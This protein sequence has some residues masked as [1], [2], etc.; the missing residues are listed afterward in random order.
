MQNC[1]FTDYIEKQQQELQKV[2]RGIKDGFRE[3]TDAL[4]KVDQEIQNAN[5]TL[6]TA[7]EV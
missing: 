2:S 7:Q 4:D 5:G 1:A 6:R 3:V